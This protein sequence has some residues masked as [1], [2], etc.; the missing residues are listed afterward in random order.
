MLIDVVQP[1]ADANPPRFDCNGIPTACHFGT[2]YWLF[3]AE[4]GR[5][6]TR[7]DQDSAGGGSS[8]EWWPPV[9]CQPLIDH[10]GSSDFCNHLG[11]TLLVVR[12]DENTARK[13]QL[14]TR[15]LGAA[16]VQVR[17]LSLTP[18]N[19]VSLA[20]WT[21]NITNMVMTDSPRTRE[22]DRS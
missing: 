4:F 12:F 22:G 15:R 16:G 19:N 8:E 2:C 5:P 10:R 6:P 11:A 13:L 3:A 18:F 14:S 21:T 1:I 7:N 20:S 17:G 9:L